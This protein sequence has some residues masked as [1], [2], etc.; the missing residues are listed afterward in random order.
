MRNLVIL[1]T[2]VALVGCGNGYRSADRG[3]SRGA[4]KIFQSK[5]SGPISRACMASDR[6]A[7]S[8]ALCGCIQ[9]VANQSLSGG[10]QRLAASFYSDPHKAQEIRQSDNLNNERFWKKYKAYGQKAAVSCR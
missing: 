2:L 8:P 6:K 3:P 4:A 9:S 1:A 10:D 7:R 5:A